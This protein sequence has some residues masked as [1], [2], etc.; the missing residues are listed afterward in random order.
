MDTLRLETLSFKPK[1]PATAGREKAAEVANTFEQLFVRSLVSSMRASA[2]MGGEG[3]MFGSGPGS[4]TYSD[5]FDENVAKQVSSSGRV[6]IAEAVLA[7]IERHHQ[8]TPQPAKPTKVAQWR[9]LD[10]KP[11]LKGGF[12]DRR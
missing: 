1:D 7:D 9:P 12:D 6:G 11:E 8:I 2:A 4:D 3:G 10:E 5:W